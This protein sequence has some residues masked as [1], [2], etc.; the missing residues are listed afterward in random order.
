MKCE[1]S[2]GIKVDYSGALRIEKGDAVNLYIK[3]RFIPAKIKGALQSA[4]RQNSC[5]ALRMAACI[6][7]DTIPCKCA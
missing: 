6:L 4:V 7:T 2:D 3:K 1:Y 5:V